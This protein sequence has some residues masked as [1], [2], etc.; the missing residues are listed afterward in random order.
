MDKP[1]L[2]SPFPAPLPFPLQGAEIAGHMGDISKVI[3]RGENVLDIIDVLDDLKDFPDA[4]RGQDL[5]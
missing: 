4:V 5:R 1:L 2:N 3:F